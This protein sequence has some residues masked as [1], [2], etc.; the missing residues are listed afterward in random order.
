MVYAAHEIHKSMYLVGLDKQE[1]CV[2]PD[3]LPLLLQ[4]KLQYV[5]VVCQIIGITNTTIFY[6]IFAQL[7]LILWII[8]GN[9]LQK[10]T[11]RGLL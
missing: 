5:Q 2:F 8:Y 10:L 4:W 1:D 11:A 9:Y 6:I 3:F 7:S